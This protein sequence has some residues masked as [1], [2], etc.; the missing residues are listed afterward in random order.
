MLY[1]IDHRL[2][3][4]MLHTLASMGHGDSIAIVDGNF[5]AASTARHCMRS[6]V[7]ALDGATTADAVKVI[8]G[9]MPLEERDLA[10]TFY[11]MIDGQ[12]DVIPPVVSEVIDAVRTSQ[13]DAGP[14]RGLERQAFYDEAKRCFAVVLTRERRFYG[15][16]IL[17]KGVIHPDR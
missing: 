15:S 10:S 13:A 14:A 2:N 5:P 17:R 12:P 6:A 4:D 3:A 9:L 16:V 8:A 7:L 11:M 1:G